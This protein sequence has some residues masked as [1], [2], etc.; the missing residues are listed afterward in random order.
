MRSSRL[1]ARSLWTAPFVCRRRFLGKDQLLPGVA[2][3]MA[4]TSWPWSSASLTWSIMTA[5]VTGD[6][7]NWE[8]AR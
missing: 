4:N 1:L 7:G 3:P 2:A 5:V 6:S 8:I